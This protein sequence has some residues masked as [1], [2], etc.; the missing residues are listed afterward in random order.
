MQGAGLGLAITKRLVELLR[1]EIS[2]SSELG[3]GTEF[4]ITFPTKPD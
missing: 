3:K 2:V 4:A 1:G